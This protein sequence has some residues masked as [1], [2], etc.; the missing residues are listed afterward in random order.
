MRSTLT[1]LLLP[2]RRGTAL[3]VVGILM[4]P[5]IGVLALVLDGGLLMQERQHAQAV[6]DA[7]AQ[8]AAI[9]LYQNNAQISTSTP[10]PNGQ[11]TK[12]A[13]ASASANGYT[14]DG[15][16][17]TVT[18]NIPPTSGPNTSALYYAEVIVQYNQTRAFSAIWS[19]SSM[20]VGARSVARGLSKGSGIGL[21]LLNPTMSGALSETGLGSVNVTGGSVIVDSNSSTCVTLKGNGSVT[22]TNINLSG[23]YSTSGN[24]T[25]SGTVKTMAAPTAD[26]YSSITPPDPSTLTVQNTGGLSYSKGSY[27]LQP[28]VYKGGISISGPASL[29]LQPGIYYMDGGGFSFT[30]QGSLTGNG[31]L[32]YNAPQSS[33]DEISLT[34]Q[35]NIT[36]TPMTSGPYTNF[37]IF[38]DRTS[39]APMNLTGN[40]AL[41]VTGIIYAAKAPL[42]LTGNGTTD[43]YGWQIIAD[44][45]TL[46][47]KGTIN[48]GK[49]GGVPSTPDIRIVE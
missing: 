29:T 43:E 15:S 19:S 23:T 22:A 40:G 28:G 27:T 46:T 1:P 33:T 34:G 26:P 18:V 20:S 12:I 36:L 45:A 21:L 11:A 25:L 3:A 47:G 17:S 32:I 31:V 24:G 37:V 35:G 6:A 2:A 48:A 14:N 49:A 9:T 13:L 30:G 39:N 10:D 42:N 7:A 8:A 5:I 44:D 38:Q 4:I 41:S 16:T